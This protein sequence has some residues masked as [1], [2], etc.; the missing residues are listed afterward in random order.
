[1]TKKLKP[2]F[3]IEGFIPAIFSFLLLG[4]VSALFGL[5]AG[6]TALGV[7]MIIYSI[8]FG[9][10]GYL[11]TKS[12]NQLVIM[13]YMFLLG[14]VF[15]MVDLHELPNGGFEYLSNSNK[16]IFVLFYFTLFWIIYLTVTKK[17]KWRGREI[18]ELA[19][20]F[21]DEADESY[22]DRPRLIGKVDLTKHELIDFSIFLKKNLICMSYVE[23]NRILL[24]PIKMGDEYYFLFNWN[25]KVEERTW[26][27]I[28]FDGQLSVHISQPDFLAYY[29][30]L[31]L[32]QLNQG[33]GDLF[34][35][36]AEQFEKG[37][38][39]RIIDRINTVKTGLFQ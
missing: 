3:G 4:V 20:E 38:Q 32:D 34:I 18:M 22:T 17:I 11:K 12:A 33:L 30:D 10:L 26:I 9:L 14:M 15:L 21:A 6:L 24:L 8:S 2:H 7:L 31:S 39:S 36:F 19:A 25:F 23:S 28:D 27:A 37:Q 1:M 35:R 16:L 29:D 5:R 13:L